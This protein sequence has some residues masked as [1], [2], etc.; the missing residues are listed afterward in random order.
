[1]IAVRRRALHLGRVREHRHPA[2]VRRP[3]ARRQPH[4]RA[5]PGLEIV[6]EAITGAQ[7]ELSVRRPLV[8]V[9]Q[10]HP[11]GDLR[12]DLEA[13]LL[14]EQEPHARA[15]L[16]QR[17]L[18]H[19]REGLRRPDLH[20]PRRGPDEPVEAPAGDQHRHAAHL[21]LAHE[22]PRVPVAGRHPDVAAH[23]EL[24]WIEVIAEE[25]E[26]QAEPEV[27]EL[28]R[29]RRRERG[30]VAARVVARL[31]QRD[32][33]VDVD[34]HAVP[35]REGAVQV[36]EELVLDDRPEVITAPLPA[37][38][39]RIVRVVTEEHQV[40]RRLPRDVRRRHAEHPVARGGRVE[41][42]EGEAALRRRRARA[43]G[44]REGRGAAAEPT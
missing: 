22:G 2:E 18:G 16:E 5:E 39:E 34:A 6:D 17:P 37:E 29:A 32:R 23:R 3:H 10:H 44:E 13:P 41:P 35:E 7:H 26:P 43:G 40:E 21:P 25:P 30:S 8:D 14:A 38:H 19:V 28:R 31:H 9:I 12:P 42:V 11:A 36:Q 1:M 4:A 24:K 33:R 15:A 20:A 27:A